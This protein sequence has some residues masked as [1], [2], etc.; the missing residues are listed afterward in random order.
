MLLFRLGGLLDSAEKVKEIAGLDELPVVREGMSEMGI[1]NFC[2]VDRDVQKRLE[3][4]LAQKAVL[5]S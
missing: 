3:E 4:W 2:V 1:V 5:Q